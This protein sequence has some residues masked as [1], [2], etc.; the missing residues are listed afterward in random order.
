MPGAVVGLIIS[1]ISSGT[2][3]VLFPIL[4]AGLAV[5]EQLDTGAVRTWI[6]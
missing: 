2:Q 6:N 3:W 1:D 5:F 4:N